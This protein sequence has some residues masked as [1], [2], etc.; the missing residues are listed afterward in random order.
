MEVAKGCAGCCPSDFIGAP[1]RVLIARARH[2]ARLLE[3]DILRFV[4]ITFNSI[5]C[6]FKHTICIMHVDITGHRVCVSTC[7]VVTGYTMR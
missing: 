6:N 5:D 3:A 4:L 1:R 7:G 2:F